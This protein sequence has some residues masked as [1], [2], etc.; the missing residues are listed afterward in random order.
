MNIKLGP[1]MRGEI[2]I[3]LC[4]G[5]QNT[6]KVTNITRENNQSKEFDPHKNCKGN[7]YELRNMGLSNLLHSMKY[8]PPWSQYLQITTSILNL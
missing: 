2:G 7:I 4:L 6:I 5:W 3:A 1:I 8:E